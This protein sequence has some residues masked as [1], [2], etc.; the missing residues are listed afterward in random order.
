M[1]RAKSAEPQKTTGDV[2]ESLIDR[3]GA[4]PDERRNSGTDDGSADDDDNTF[5]RDPEDQGPEDDESD[6]E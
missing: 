2:L 5:E 4:G 3:T 6:D 1:A